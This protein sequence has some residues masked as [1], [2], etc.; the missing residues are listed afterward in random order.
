[1]NKKML[2]LMCGAPG[3]GKSTYAEKHIGPND[4]YISRDEIRFDL[5]SENEEYFSKEKQVF[6]LFVE[7]IQDALNTEGIERVICDATHINER[8]RDKLCDAL[9]MTNVDSIR[10]W[11]VRPAI[12]ETVQRNLERKGTRA[13]VP[14]SAVRRMYF[15]F[16]RPEE[17]KNYPKDVQYVEVPAAWEKFG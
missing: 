11:V 13:Y 7:K 4:A 8:S 10:C 15:S 5:V 14:L 9:D 2:I 12:E 1:M 6:A 3:S 16:E 17:D